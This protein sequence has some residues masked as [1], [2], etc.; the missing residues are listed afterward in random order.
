MATAA[1]Q[2]KWREK[3]RFTK[4]QLNVMARKQIHEDLEE[5]VAAFG[6]RGKAEAV[7]FTT[8]ITRALSQNAEHNPEARR[9]LALFREAFE[10]DR[11]LYAP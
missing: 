1:A 11:D 2:Q 7:T 5:M 4:R 9:L 8:F 6:L 10:R 3:N